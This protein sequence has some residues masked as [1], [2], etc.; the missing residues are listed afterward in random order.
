MGSQEIEVPA[1][2]A[3]GVPKIKTLTKTSSGSTNNYSSSNIGGK[4]PGGNSK[5]KKADKVKKSDVVERYKEINDQIE[6]LTDAI[7]DASKVADRLYG[8]SRLKQMQ[9]QNDLIKDEIDLLK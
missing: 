2:S 5:P 1:L 8:A 9:K 4:G 3:D 7:D 6:K